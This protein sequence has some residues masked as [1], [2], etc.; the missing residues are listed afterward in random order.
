MRPQ[1]QHWFLNFD[2]DDGRN[3]C[4]MHPASSSALS[5]PHVRCCTMAHTA[6]MCT[7]FAA[8]LQATYL[9]TVALQLRFSC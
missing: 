8:V 9:H 6:T 5:N 3:C 7:L 1:Q 2:G 4:T